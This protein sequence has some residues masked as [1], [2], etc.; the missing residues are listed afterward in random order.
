MMPSINSTKPTYS[1]LCRK[2]SRKP[3]DMF[4]HVVVP[5]Y[6]E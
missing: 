2:V 6:E 4:S 1:Q 5:V 3:S